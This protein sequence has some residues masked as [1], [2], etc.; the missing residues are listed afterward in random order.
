[1]DYVKNTYH[2]FTRN[3]GQKARAPHPSSPALSE[4]SD[5][6]HSSADSVKPNAHDLPGVPRNAPYSQDLE[7]TKRALEK[8]DRTLLRAQSK[9]QDLQS[10]YDEMELELQE[11]SSKVA[12]LKA[13]SRDAERERDRTLRA[14]K[15][16][17][18]HFERAQR[19]MQNRT[20]QLESQYRD[21]LARTGE[22]ERALA[23]QR[24]RTT[25]MEALL[26][27]RTTELHAAQSFL[28]R[29]DD[30][31]DSEVLRLITTLNAR[32]Y[33]TAA[34]ISDAYHARCGMEKDD[35]TDAYEEVLR[36][37]M[38][39]ETVVEAMRVASHGGD[40][41]LLQT[42]VETILATAAHMLCSFWVEPGDSQQEC[43]HEQVY[44]SMK[45]REPQPVAGRW[46]TLYR[47][48]LRSFCKTEDEF[49]RW[50]R[51]WLADLIAPVLCVCGVPDTVDD[52]RRELRRAH[53]GGFDD[54]ARN[55]LE[56]RRVVGETVVSR[57]FSVIT[58]S[59][60]EAFD[61]GRM[62]DEWP[63]PRQSQKRKVEIPTVLCTTALGLLREE[64]G[65]G[66]SSGRVALLVRPKVVLSSLLTSL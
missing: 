42:G 36:S 60:G 32:I 28:D 53:A 25:A 4:C 49:C 35:T 51:R 26:D 43:I 18:R 33:Q 39:S 2:V 23:A 66:K 62:E 1:M 45:A 54:I 50:T 55:A 57:D 40:S 34:S 29:A 30:V 24:D 19:E 47:S 31:A 48:H 11:A 22:S 21:A 61:D 8:K 15:D 13:R 44:R 12:K 20:V 59:I 9:L 17:A 58:A 52:L 16:N 56:F 27:T 7:A 41:I 5:T 6:P 65:G 14:A 3:R 10:R 63:E 46:R 38:L 37:G 64:T